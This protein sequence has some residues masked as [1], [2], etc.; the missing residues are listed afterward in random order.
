MTEETI[1]D[2]AALSCLR[3]VIEQPLEPPRVPLT[4]SRMEQRQYELRAE[5][6]KSWG[7]PKG[8]TYIRSKKRDYSKLIQ[9][10]EV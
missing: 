5:Q 2:E 7:G 10:P 3:E 8:N 4:V 9:G 1:P 6:A